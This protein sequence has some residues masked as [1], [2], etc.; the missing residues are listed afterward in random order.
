MMAYANE[1][2]EEVLKHVPSLGPAGLWFNPQTSGWLVRS[3][4][5]GAGMAVGEAAV[6]KAAVDKAAVGGGG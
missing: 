5:E 3:F 2:E 4:T 6:D 1:M